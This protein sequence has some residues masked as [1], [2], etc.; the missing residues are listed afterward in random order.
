MARPGAPE[1]IK[2]EAG[3]DAMAPPGLWGRGRSARAKTEAE[4]YARIGWINLDSGGI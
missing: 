2:P 4:T 3:R 1:L